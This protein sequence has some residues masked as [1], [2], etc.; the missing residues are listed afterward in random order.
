MKRLSLGLAVVAAVT[1]ASPAVAHDNRSGFD[2]SHASMVEPVMAGVSVDPIITVGDTLG[3]GYRF[4]AIPDGIAVATRGN[5]RVDL[6]VNHETGR[7]PFPYNTAAPTAANGENDFDNSQVSRLVLNAHSAG[8]LSGKFVIDASEGYQRFCSNYLATKADGLRL[9]TSC[10]PTRRRPTTSDAPPTA[11]RSRS[12]VPSSARAA[13]SSPTTS[14]PAPRS[15]STAWAATI[16]RTASRFRAT[17][18]RSSSPATT[19]SR[20]AR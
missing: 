11:G 10:S 7:V 3:S 12:A 19:R 4:E 18:T 9:A 13:L 2:T 15:R 5:G 16:T 20:A 14:G 6:Y 8:V 17:A 1:L